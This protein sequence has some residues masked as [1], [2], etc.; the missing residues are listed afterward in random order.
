MSRAFLNALIVGI[1]VLSG[2]CA[3]RAE[4]QS[5]TVRLPANLDGQGLRV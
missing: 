2:F 4:A 3:K 5:P 1:V